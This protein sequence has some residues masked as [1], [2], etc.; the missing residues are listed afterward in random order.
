MYTFLMEKIN[1]IC[2]IEDEHIQNFLNRK[3]IE[4]TGLVHLVTEYLNGK[5]AFEAM[6]KRVQSELTLPDIIFLDLNMPVW[7]GWDFFKAFM[8]LP[9]SETTTIYILTS[10]LSEDDYKMAEQFGLRERYLEKPLGFGTLESVLS[11]Y[12]RSFDPK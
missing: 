6:E 3:F 7:D 4:K 12:T 2:L 9:G 1:E 8:G 10:S 11:A 5:E